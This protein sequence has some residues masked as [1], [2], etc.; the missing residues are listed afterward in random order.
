[1]TLPSLY[2]A[3]ML[4]TFLTRRHTYA[5]WDLFGEGGYALGFL[6]VAGKKVGE[7]YG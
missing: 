3:F 1:L 2:K 6:Y 5:G 4:T 7:L